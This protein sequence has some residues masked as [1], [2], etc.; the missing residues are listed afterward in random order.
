MEYKTIKK[1][2]EGK[3]ILITGNTGFVGSWL[4]TALYY[5]G[6]NIIGYS[7]KKR[8]KNLFLII[9]YLVKK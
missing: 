9:K 5:L 7:L 8:I 1:K 2:I 3:K 6:A 4:S